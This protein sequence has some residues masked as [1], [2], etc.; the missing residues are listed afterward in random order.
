MDGPA[1]DAIYDGA[2]EFT[3]ILEATDIT[4]SRLLSVFYLS[5]SLLD[6]AGLPCFATEAIYPNFISS[7]T[8]PASLALPFFKSFLTSSTIKRSI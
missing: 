8:K 7:F 6:G 5:D 1:I 2:F 3:L 4:S